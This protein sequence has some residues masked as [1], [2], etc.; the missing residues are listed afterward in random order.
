MLGGECTVPG[1]GVLYP[2]NHF[3]HPLPSSV[4]GVATALFP[5]EDFFYLL[6]ISASIFQFIGVALIISKKVQE[7]KYSFQTVYV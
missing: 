4:L 3:R 2:V 6:V 1:R 7:A 5:E